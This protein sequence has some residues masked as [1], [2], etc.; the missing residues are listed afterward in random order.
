MRMLKSQK[1]FAAFDRVMLEAY[2]R[3][4]LRILS[5]CVMG[6]HGT[7]SPGRRRTGS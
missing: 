2:E 4:P 1:D 7:S 5:Y 6:N 3:F